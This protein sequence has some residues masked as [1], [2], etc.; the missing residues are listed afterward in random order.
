M[1]F[2]RFT[3]LLLTTALLFS[4]TACDKAGQGT[5]SEGTTAFVGPTTPAADNSTPDLVE[6]APSGGGMPVIVYPFADIND[7]YPVAEYRLG[8][9][10][11]E[12]FR[13][14]TAYIDGDDLPLLD[15]FKL[16]TPDVYEELL[17]SMFSP[18]GELGFTNIDAIHETPIL[19]EFAADAN[20]LFN[21]SFNYNGNKGVGDSDVFTSAIRFASEI[22]AKGAISV[23]AGKLLTA[24][25]AVD[26]ASS[27]LGCGE[28][29][30]GEYLVNPSAWTTALISGVTN[31][32]EYRAVTTSKTDDGL[33]YLLLYDKTDDNEL[34]FVVNPTN[35]T[36]GVTLLTDS[37]GDQQKLRYQKT[38]FLA[39]YDDD[40]YDIT[41]DVFYP[42]DKDD[43]YG[44]SLTVPAKAITRVTSFTL[45]DAQPIDEFVELPE[46]YL[47]NNG[48][49]FDGLIPPYDD[50]FD[51]DDDFFKLN[52]NAPRYGVVEQG[53]FAVQP[54]EVTYGDD[55]NPALVGKSA[56]SSVYIGDGHWYNCA[57]D[58]KIRPA[59]GGYVKLTFGYRPGVKDSGISLKVLSS[60]TWQVTVDGVIKKSGTAEFDED[61]NQMS[62]EAYDS[63]NASFNDEDL[64]TEEFAAGYEMKPGFV[65]VELGG[66]GTAVDELYV[67]GYTKGV[68][69]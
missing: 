13:G 27:L 50:D 8:D 40:L 47:I 5:E 68:K 61:V 12:V 21:V 52:K 58:L 28:P 35:E 45:D 23:S 31:H 37:L 43:L 67:F 14:F 16:D 32:G 44:Y 42:N 49:Y 7:D 38:L 65:R 17:I 4:I 33:I 55:E 24:V 66:I 2:K 30:S 11:G 6:T 56:V 51:Y 59:L 62:V 15:D 22:G 36:H 20:S 26:Y 29:W 53:T 69:P 57:V 1:T 34:F 60:G 10:S 3:A 48:Y 25:A 18:D 19:T 39:D 9:V 46:P 41:D 63:L 54:A 64:F